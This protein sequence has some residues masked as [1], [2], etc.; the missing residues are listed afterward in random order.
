[1]RAIHHYFLQ[2]IADTI[3]FNQI[4]LNYTNYLESL[5]NPKAT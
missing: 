5:T 2:N 3:Q 4:A 1:M